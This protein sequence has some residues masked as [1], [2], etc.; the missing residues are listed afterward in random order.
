[1]EK[2]GDV[3]ITSPYSVCC[4]WLFRKGSLGSP[5]EPRTY[6]DPLAPVCRV[7]GIHVGKSQH[8]GLFYSSE[9]NICLNVSTERSCLNV[10]LISLLGN[11]KK[12]T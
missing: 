1:M 12:K 10:S 9:S 4:G 8:T 2:T 11:V 3:K 7:L 5:G 6:N